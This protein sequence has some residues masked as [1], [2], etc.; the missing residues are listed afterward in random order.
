[1]NAMGWTILIKLKPYGYKTGQLGENEI[2]MEIQKKKPF[3]LRIGPVIVISFLFIF[4][5]SVF[6]YFVINS[7]Y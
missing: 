2:L 3:K 4:L 5:F 1:M 7:A 6:Y